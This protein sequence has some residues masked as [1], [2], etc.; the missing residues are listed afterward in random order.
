[1][2]FFDALA[3]FEEYEPDDDDI[4]DED[5]I[6]CSV[7]GMIVLRS[8]DPRARD[9]RCCLDCYYEKF[10]DSD[11]LNISHSWYDG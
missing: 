8:S 5:Y 2:T 7:C 6:T 4:I 3:D 1:M 11:N 9:N 10:W